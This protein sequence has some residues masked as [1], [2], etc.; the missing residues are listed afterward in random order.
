MNAITILGIIIFFA[1]IITVFWLLWKVGNQNAVNANEYDRRYILIDVLI[2]KFNVNR[3]NYDYL[4]KMLDGL[5]E[6][7][8]KDTARTIKLIDKFNAKF[9]PE[10][11]RIMKEH[12]KEIE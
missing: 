7:K 3:L 6:L 11:S 1:A 12:L 10:A 5:R 4:L 2:E 8:Y 9:E